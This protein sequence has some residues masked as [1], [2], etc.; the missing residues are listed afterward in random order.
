M[1]LVLLGMGNVRVLF[2]R[3]SKRGKG[4][5]VRLEFISLIRSLGIVKDLERFYFRF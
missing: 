1:Y 2:L 4:V 5:K 3:G